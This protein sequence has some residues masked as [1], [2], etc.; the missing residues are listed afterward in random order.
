MNVIEQRTPLGDGS[1][2]LCHL[3]HPRPVR[4]PYTNLGVWFVDVGF[5]AYLDVHRWLRSEI[6]RK[7]LRD[8][9]FVEGKPSDANDPW[10]VSFTM[11]GHLDL[12]GLGGM[13]D[14][15][16]E[17]GVTGRI[18]YLEIGPRKR[19]SSGVTRRVVS[20]PNPLGPVLQIK[21]L[22]ESSRVRARRLSPPRKHV[23]GGQAGQ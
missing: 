14:K 17:L 18:V 6:E 11:L 2:I 15:L 4:K 7:T 21:G 9:Y 22:D 16:F 5:S 3:L 12:N 20:A 23:L 19:G 13:L 10:T 1:G 8:A